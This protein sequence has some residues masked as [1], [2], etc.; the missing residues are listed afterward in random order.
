MSDQRS[1]PWVTNLP[2]AFRLSV[3]SLL[4]QPWADT[5]RQ[6]VSSSSLIY[7]ARCHVKSRI[8]GPGG[9]LIRTTSFQSGGDNRLPSPFVGLA[10]TLY[11]APGSRSDE[12]L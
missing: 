11:F 5:R 10:T 12:M 4:P 6:R 3:F 7:S 8:V 2:E 9:V 1:R